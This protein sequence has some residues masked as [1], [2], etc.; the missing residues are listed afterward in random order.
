MDSRGG[1]CECG[2][3]VPGT[4]RP[5]AQTARPDDTL[6]HA[7]GS[8]EMAAFGIHDSACH[9]AMFNEGRHH[10]RWSWLWQGVAW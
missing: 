9:R 4:R 6:R 2:G 8:V 7:T 5:D 3:M 1:E 10:G